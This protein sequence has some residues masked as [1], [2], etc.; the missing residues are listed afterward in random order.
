[1]Q[2]T[3]V[4]RS[5]VGSCRGPQRCDQASGGEDGSDLHGRRATALG[6]T[7]GKYTGVCEQAVRVGGRRVQGELAHK[8]PQN[9]V[10]CPHPPGRGRLK[11]RSR[12]AGS[13]TPVMSVAQAHHTLQ[14]FGHGDASAVE[15]SD[16]HGRR[17]ARTAIAPDPQHLCRL[18]PAARETGH[19]ENTSPRLLVARSR[20]RWDISMFSYDW[21]PE[22]SRRPTRPWNGAR[23]ARASIRRRML[24]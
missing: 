6:L 20:P 15:T 13:A 10:E 11:N 5:R 17:G 19:D 22:G 1:V 7:A 16:H 14:F 23:S 21:W 18:G 4:D 2:V 3:I 12:S 8:P 24:R 9:T